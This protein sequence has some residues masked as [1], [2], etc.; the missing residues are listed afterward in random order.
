[1]KPNFTKRNNNLG[2]Y[3]YVVENR[4]QFIPSLSNKNGV[5]SDV[6]K[7]QLKIVDLLYGECTITMHTVFFYARFKDLFFNLCVF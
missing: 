6:T 5:K 2:E 7:K 3:R 4:Q 1:M